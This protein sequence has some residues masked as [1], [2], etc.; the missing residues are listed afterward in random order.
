MC[1]GEEAVAGLEEAGKALKKAVRDGGLAGGVV[2][3]GRRG[4]V[5]LLEAAGWRRLVPSPLPT[6]PNTVFDLASLTKPVVTATLASQLVEAGELKLDYPVKAYLPAFRGDGRDEATVRDLLTHSSGVPA[7]KN[8]LADPPTGAAG[9]QERLEAVVADICRLPLVARP[10]EQFVY[11]DL[12]FIL[13]GAVIEG[14]LGKPLDQAA[15][16]RIFVPAAMGGACFNPPALLWEACAATE[17][18]EGRVLQGVVHDENARYLGGVAGHAG[19][20][21]TAEDLGRYC[22]MMLHGGMG[23]AGRV[24]WPGTVA[25]MT[26][27]QSRH[28]DQRRG[29]GWDLDSKYAI[30][31]RGDVFPARGFGHSGFTGTSL[32]VD[33]P[34]GA[35][36]VLL[37]NQVHPSRGDKEVIGALRREVAN[38]VARAI[39]RR[40]PRGR[41]TA[42]AGGVATGFEVERGR[43]WPTLRDKRIGLLTNHS[44]I[45]SR[46]RHLAD[47]LAAWAGVDLVRLFAPEHGLRGEL[48][49]PFGDGVDAAT[50]LQVLSLY[51][52]RQ[53]PAADDLADLDAIVFDIQDAGVRFY[54]YT[55]TLALAM[56]A[57]A[58]ANVEV[59]VLDR[60]SLLRPDIVD[61]PLLD[62]PFASLAEYHPLPVVHGLTAGELARYANQEYRI[63]ARL[64]VVACENYRRDMWFD[65][66]GLPWVNPSPN[67]RSPTAA[68]L[69]PALGMLER[70]NLSVGRGTGEPFEVFGAPWMDGAELARTLN[71]WG[72]AGLS[73][74]PVRF[75]PAEREFR[76]QDCS[77]CRVL[78]LDREAYQPV[79]T[80]LRIAAAI[81]QLW[82]NK[83]NIQAVSGLLG[84]RQAVERLAEGVAV[85][86][87]MKRW[88][89]PLADYL[90]R[91]QA[92]LL[93]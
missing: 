72:L 35:W 4:E 68:I 54:T 15:V 10:G 58:E 27:T 30:Q 46:R 21:A 91:R 83:L 36:V 16:E 88:Q 90:A 48:D 28:P 93:Y 14:L 57:A 65:E 56:K 73:F 61:G 9:R 20:F 22:A 78:L 82:P 86:E 40:T 59:V 24:L 69:Y 1:A 66:T 60:P 34:S 6:L 80:G 52:A 89:A 31:I 26:T 87:V 37:T 64:T 49:E 92:Y 47:V 53:A 18:V 75:T 70:C 17:V 38:A 62:R 19:L 77:G 5:L 33:P 25:A 63:G 12:G 11:S 81:E 55:A 67:L 74:E 7:W 32:W 3:A 13:L 43:G 45:D 51:G 76:G 41:K 44:A 29:L 23:V 85:E 42:P 8:Y 79:A 84:D 39:I 71:A 2:A 50:G